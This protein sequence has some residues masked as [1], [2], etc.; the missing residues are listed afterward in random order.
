MRNERFEEHSLDSLLDAES[1]EE[2]GVPEIHDRYN[3]SADENVDGNLKNWTAE[4]FASIHVRFRP[5]LERHAR[6]YLSN[7]VQAEEVVQEA[8]LY[9]MTTLPELDS[10]LGVLKFLKWKTRLLC[11]DVLRSASTQ[12]ETPVPDHADYASETDEISAE[13]ERAE[14][15]AVIRMALSTL[16][17]RQREVLVASVYEEKT[18][19]ELADQLSLSPNATRQLLFRAR[20]AFKKALIGEAEIQ[21]K[22]VTQ[23]LSIA[24]RKA[25]SDS[26]RNAV[27][28]GAFVLFL[29]VGLG[30]I[31]SMMGET[32]QTA[33]L[34]ASSPVSDTSV[35]DSRAG[36]AAVEDPNPSSITNSGADSDNESREIAELDVFPSGEGSYAEI[37]PET[38]ASPAKPDFPTQEDSITGEIRNEQAQTASSSMTLDQTQVE[39]ILATQADQA[40]IYADSYS[41]QFADVFSGVSI[42]VFGGTGISAFLDFDPESKSINAVVY[43][44]SIRGENFSA[45]P[46]QKRVF[47]SSETNGSRIEITSSEF[48]LV[49][50]Q[51]RVFEQSP[52]FGA[53]VDVVLRLDESGTP[54]NASI[55]VTKQS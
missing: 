39:T 48:Y 24:A 4:D 43:Q 22:S 28:I 37:E 17:P 8:F 29:A 49:D 20:S 26:R 55:R 44:I 32:S 36:S 34:V 52:L 27:N 54:N 15:N 46:K 6:R 50:S 14:D 9:L 2:F 23:I 7:S 40:G 31:P 45:I 35:E 33:D 13:L 10:E 25:A 42:E 30:V 38:I 1:E 47:T 12:R 51:G 19:E 3:H 11:L 16:N 18:T 21:G 53:I 41:R 5:H